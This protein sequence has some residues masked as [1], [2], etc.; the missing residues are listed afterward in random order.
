[1]VT[2]SL[3]NESSNERIIAMKFIVLAMSIYTAEWFT[4]EPDIYSWTARKDCEYF[5]EHNLIKEDGFVYGC[6][7]VD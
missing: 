2:K 6:A 7:L 1:M 4:V 3:Q 5:I